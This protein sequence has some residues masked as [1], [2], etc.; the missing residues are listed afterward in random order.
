M[1][2]IRE[3]EASREASL[4]EHIRFID[5]WTAFMQANSNAVWSAQQREFIDGL[6]GPEPAGTGPPA[7]A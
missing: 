2:E 7:S 1:V 5:F 3:L 4:R 6:L